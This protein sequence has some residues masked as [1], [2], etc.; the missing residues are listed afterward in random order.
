MIVANFSH[1][2][3]LSSLTLPASSQFAHPTELERISWPPN[4]VHISLGGWF[5]FQDPQVRW[6][7]FAKKWPLSLQSVVL[8]DC[9]CDRDGSGDWTRFLDT[10]HGLDSVHIAL[11]NEYWPG[12]GE[13][14]LSSC[15]GA[16]RLSLPANLAGINY[17]KYDNRPRPRL[18]QLEIVQPN[19]M[20]P[21]KFRPSDLIA[22]IREIPTMLQIRI[23]RS[24]LRDGCQSVETGNKLLSDRGSSRNREAGA[25]GVNQ[26][27][28]RVIILDDW[29]LHIHGLQ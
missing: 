21:H 13:D 24:L 15:S 5:G 11:Q 7:H 8:G 16:R 20:G 3:G 19:C 10:P 1:L 4:L 26:K 12:S 29:F 6:E 18:Q 17:D 9:Y 23:A 14:L 2:T 25:T 28:C 22:H 27:D